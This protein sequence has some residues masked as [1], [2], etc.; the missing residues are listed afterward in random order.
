MNLAGTHEWFNHIT[1]QSAPR[2][3]NDCA[4]SIVM[5]QDASSHHCQSPEKTPGRKRHVVFVLFPSRIHF[6]CWGRALRHLWCKSGWNHGAE[7]APQ[8]NVKDHRGTPPLRIQLPPQH[9]PGAR[10]EPGQNSWPNYQ[11]PP[12]MKDCRLTIKLKYSKFTNV[13]LCNCL[14]T[15]STWRHCAISSSAFNRFW[16]LCHKAWPEVWGSSMLA[17]LQCYQRKLERQ[18][19]H[20]TVSL[21]ESSSDSC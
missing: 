15:R 12:A 8:M 19:Q 18:M 3:R 16:A 1:T 5:H 6:L 4:I 7:N 9:G 2:G 13:P 20:C 21:S 17:H 11:V 10:D 14:R